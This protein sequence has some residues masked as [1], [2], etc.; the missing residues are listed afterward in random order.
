MSFRQQAEELNER[1]H[2][3]VGHMFRT[4]RVVDQDGVRLV[5][6]LVSSK[7]GD[8]PD[9]EI[10]KSLTDL[11]PGGWAVRRASGKTDRAFY[12]YVLTRDPIEI[13]GS[14]FKIH[15]GVVVK[16]SEVGYTSLWV[17]PMAYIPHMDAVSVFEADVK[18]RRI[19]RGS[20]EALA[21]DLKT[22]LK[23][24]STVW[25]GVEDRLSRL[26][27]VVFADEEEAI[28]RMK[29]V[30]IG[31]GSTKL[32]ALRCEQAYKAGKHALHN[33]LTVYEAVLERVYRET[34]RDDA[35]TKAALA[36][37]LLYKLAP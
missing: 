3:F 31:A 4:M 12:A 22:A 11:L 1:R 15:P 8:I 28:E 34:N 9:T 37:A 33:G 10:M 21:E 30:L 17:Y 27:T 5:R 23:E 18:L 16:N 14:Y 2:T 20:N 35:Y 24:V 26:R 36:G 32:F 13:P 6:G 7:Y 19:H 29:R 25:G